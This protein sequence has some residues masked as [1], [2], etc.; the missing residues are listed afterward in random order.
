MY[1]GKRRK[2]TLATAREK[3]EKLSKNQSHLVQT[4]FTGP[5]HENLVHP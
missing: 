3:L 1:G 2:A 4:T 5:N